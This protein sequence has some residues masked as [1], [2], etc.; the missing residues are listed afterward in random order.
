MY[1][2]QVGR[3][4][5]GDQS[6][7]ASGGARLLRQVQ[8]GRV[9][10]GRRAVERGGAGETPA[11]R[12]EQGFLGHH[13]PSLLGSLLQPLNEPQIHQCFRHHPA[14]SRLMLDLGIQLWIERYTPP[15]LGADFK[16]HLVGF[17]PIVIQTVCIPE[18]G[19]PIH[20]CRLGNA[21]ALLRLRL[22]GDWAG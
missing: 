15:L 13:I 6:Q 17:I 8:L 11:V 14:T 5:V 21:A 12:G 18:L 9:D 4:A 3:A 20:R 19:Y 1:L 16:G 10:D 22:R 7:E 2:V